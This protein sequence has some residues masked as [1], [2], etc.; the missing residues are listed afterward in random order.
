MSA[1]LASL[2]KWVRKHEVLRF[3]CRCRGRV[4]CSENRCGQSN[5]SVSLPGLRTRTPSRPDWSLRSFTAPARGMPTFLL[6]K[7]TP[8]NTAIIHALESHGFFIMDMVLNFV[9]DFRTGGQKED[10]PQV[11]E[12][13]V[14]RLA[15]SSDIESFVEIVRAS[16]AGHFG[17]FHADPGLAAPLRRGFTRNG[18]GRARMAGRIGFSSRCRAIAW[19]DIPSGKNLPLLTGT[20]VFGL[21]ISASQLCILIFSDAEFSVL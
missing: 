14:L 12:G 5:I 8:S 11:P 16:F 2:R 19:P 21:V 13:F 17:R 20:M 15:T 3:A 6:C 1:P 9:F 10:A 7:T 18:F 4:H